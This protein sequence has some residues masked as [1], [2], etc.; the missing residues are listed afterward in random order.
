MRRRPQDSEN[1]GQAW[2]THL[3]PAEW[4]GDRH[5]D[6][7]WPVALG[8]WRDSHAM[9]GWP[10]L[11]SGAPDAFEHAPALGEQPSRVSTSSTK[12]G[13]VCCERQE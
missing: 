2:L 4:G 7:R 6:C 10:E 1:A 9:D 5:A 12:T 3:D 8:K 11:P 13:D